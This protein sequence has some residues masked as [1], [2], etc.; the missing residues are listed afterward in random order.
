M[1]WGLVRVVIFATA[2]LF[3]LLFGSGVVTHNSATASVQARPDMS[4]A[5]CNGA[6]FVLVR[7]QTG[8]MPL[9]AMNRQGEVLQELAG[10]VLAKEVER[11]FDETRIELSAAASP[12]FFCG[13]SECD[14]CVVGS[15]VNHRVY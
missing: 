3:G 10:D 2:F 6:S 7:T 15:L 5:R 13:G 9:N 14:W 11:P 1:E 4:E 8:R 12:H